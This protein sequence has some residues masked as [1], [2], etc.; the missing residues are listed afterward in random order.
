MQV[1]LGHIYNECKD[2]ESERAVN[3]TSNPNAIEKYQSSNIDQ[4]QRNDIVSSAIYLFITT[5]IIVLESIYVLVKGMRRGV[6]KKEVLSQKS[7]LGFD[8][9]IIIKQ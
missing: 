3:F 6:L 9:D 1:Y 8:I 2:Q 5:I 7:N 4:T